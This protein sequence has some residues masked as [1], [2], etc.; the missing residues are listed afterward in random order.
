MLIF[1]MLCL[2]SFVGT[3]GRSVY[4]DVFLVDIVQVSNSLCKLYIV[5][6]HVPKDFFFFYICVHFK[7]HFCK[8]G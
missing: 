7:N 3:S 1:N 2:C 6:A 5:K 8:R 4:N